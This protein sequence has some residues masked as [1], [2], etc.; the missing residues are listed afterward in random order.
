M[1]RLP[2]IRGIATVIVCVVLLGGMRCSARAQEPA[3]FTGKWDMQDNAGLAFGL[4]LQQNGDTLT[5][6]HCGM[7]SDASRID[8]SLAGEDEPTIVGSI[9]DTVA[10]VRFTS[11]YSGQIGM[12]K[13]T[14]LD[15]S[16]LW[17]ITAYPNGVYYLPDQAVLTKTETLSE[18]ESPVDERLE[19]LHELVSQ[20]LRA[21]A[22]AHPVQFDQEDVVYDDI[23]ADG[24]EDVAAIFYAVDES[25]SDMEEGAE[26]SFLAVGFG[27]AADELTLALNAET[28]PDCAEV[29]DETDVSLTSQ[30]GMLILARSGGSN[31]PW[32]Q[33]QKIQYEAG[34]FKVIGYTTNSSLV[35]G[36]I[37]FGYDLNLNTLEAVRTY[38]YQD[39]GGEQRGAVR[40]TTL[41]AQYASSPITIDGTL[42]EAAWVSARIANIRH[43]SAVVYKPENWTGASDL[44]FAAATLWDTGGLYV[45]LV[46]ED[47]TVVPVES[48]EA[49]LKGDHLEL[50]LD[51]AM[52][53]VQ[54]DVD[55][56]PLRQQPDG[57]ILQIGMGVPEPEAEPIVRILYPEDFQEPFEIQAATSLTQS[58]Y[59]L[60]MYVPLSII[61]QLAPAHDEWKW[62]TGFDF[63]LSLVVSDTDNPDNRRQDCLMATSEV[64]WGNPY[65]FGTGYLVETYMVPDFPLREW[66]ER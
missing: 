1:N 25:V 35:G 61:E 66:R 38:A 50:W 12:A 63:G 64:K 16:L 49:I 43:S 17:E 60:E 33:A 65:T 58:G 14:L 4:E 59:V 30:N 9:K 27:N 46:V 8:C 48:W 31:W 6:H 41:M 51:G 47:E 26:D 3:D 42:N 34:H 36:G 56:S 13:L 44:S 19:R 45:G 20:D 28:C 37:S 21:Q 10:K 23:N 11:A 15:G 2:H 7:T 52:G 53:L 55:D 5:G 22:Y 32:E 62:R 40:F 54:W 24:V 39:D 57:N 29:Y 18:R